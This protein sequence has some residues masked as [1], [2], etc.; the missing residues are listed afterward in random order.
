MTDKV[1]SRRAEG[2]IAM[3]GRHVDKCHE[4]TSGCTSP[5]NK[6]RARATG[7]RKYAFPDPCVIVFFSCCDM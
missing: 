3:N 6:C 4:W 5:M 2:C 7:R 1:N